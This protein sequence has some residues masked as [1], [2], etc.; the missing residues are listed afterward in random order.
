MVHGVIIK[1]LYLDQ[2]ETRQR[3]DSPFVDRLARKASKCF[4]AAHPTG[5]IWV[6]LTLLYLPLQHT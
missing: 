6:V 1:V 5:V 4:D 3:F 2:S